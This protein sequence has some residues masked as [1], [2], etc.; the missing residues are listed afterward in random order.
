MLLAGVV[1]RILVH[2]M[3]F[4][5]RG[6]MASITILYLLGIPL[7]RA[8][9]AYI[10]PTS[11]TVSSSFRFPTISYQEGLKHIHSLEHLE[12][13]AS[14]YFRIHRASQPIRYGDFV[15]I[16]ADCLIQGAH[17]TICVMARPDL[18]HTCTYMCLQGAVQRAQI[19]LRVHKPKKA[20]GHVLTMQTTY[21]S[22]KRVLDRDIGPTMRFLNFF[23]E[24]TKYQGVPFKAHPNLLWYRRMVLGLPHAIDQPDDYLEGGLSS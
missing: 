8:F 22:G 17:H 24:K 5:L 15:T 4:I 3:Q 12:T 1:L 16:N 10:P 23:E 21:F 6:L 2:H 13:I 20:P 7:V 14:G 9:P 11:H 18:N 19:Q